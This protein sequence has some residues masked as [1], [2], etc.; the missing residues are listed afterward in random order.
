MSKYIPQM[1]GKDYSKVS[2]KYLKENT[3]TIGE[4]SIKYDGHYTQLHYNS[5]FQILKVYSSSGAVILKQ[6]GWQ[7]GSDDFIVE[8][9]FIGTSKGEFGDR[10]QVGA[11]SSWRSKTSKGEEF[12][13]EDNVFMVFN[14]LSG[15]FPESIK[16]FQLVTKKQT[17]LAKAMHDCKYFYTAGWEGVMWAQLNIP[18]VPGSRTNSMIKFK[19]LFKKNLLCINVIEGLGNIAGKV[20]SL[21]LEDSDGNVVK[22]GSGLT[23]KTRLPIAEGDIYIGCQIDISYEGFINTYIQP[24]ID[25]IYLIKEDA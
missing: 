15:K 12:S 5:A 9:E 23:N 4:L 20:G 22:V 19:Q 1:K 18:Y 14:I 8:A 25:Q 3:E 21:L 10:I 6:H 13:I 17:T 16:N 24:R 2:A 7:L 11:L